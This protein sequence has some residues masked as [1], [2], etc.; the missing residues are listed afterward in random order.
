[1]DNKLNGEQ[2]NHLLKRVDESQKNKELGIELKA[3]IFTEELKKALKID[4]Y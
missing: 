1:M 3:I 2:K 4:R